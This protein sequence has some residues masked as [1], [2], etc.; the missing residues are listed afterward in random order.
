LCQVKNQL[1]R[2]ALYLRHPLGQDKIRLPILARYV[3]R[4]RLVRVVLRASENGHAG[5]GHDLIILEHGQEGT[6]IRRLAGR[7]NLMRPDLLFHLS[8]VAYRYQVRHR[9]TSS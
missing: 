2:F 1:I 6:V 7:A 3:V 8:L 5:V 9:F 4:A